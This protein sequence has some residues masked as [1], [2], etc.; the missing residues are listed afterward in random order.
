MKL[1][2][3][4]IALG[5]KTCVIL[6]SPEVLGVHVLNRSRGQHWKPPSTT[7][8]FPP[9]TDSSG[10]ILAQPTSLSP[11]PML[12]SLTPGTPAQGHAPTQIQPSSVSQFNM[13]AAAAAARNFA[14]QGQFQPMRFDVTALNAATAGYFASPDMNP[15]GVSGSGQ[16]SGAGPGGGWNR[17]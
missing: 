4:C 15:L 12:S 16:G 8:T 6:C 2:R 14:H 5:S 17:R 1:W 10:H 9:T 3:S 7:A 13:L 11:P